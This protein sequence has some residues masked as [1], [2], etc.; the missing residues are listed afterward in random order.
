MCREN[1][2]TLGWKALSA[3]VIAFGIFICA[4]NLFS[5][6][7]LSSYA[8]AYLRELQFPDYVVPIC[9]MAVSVAQVM[10]LRARRSVAQPAIGLLSVA[11]LP[12]TSP[13]ILLC[14]VAILVVLLVIWKES[15]SE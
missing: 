14:D 7:Y 4:G 15:K 3:L 11:R 9:Q 13:L 2:Q 1:E 10:F 6:A 5:I 8:N 12:F